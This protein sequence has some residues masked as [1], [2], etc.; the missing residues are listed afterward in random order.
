MVRDKMCVGIT[1]KGEFMVR[2]NPDEQESALKRKGARMMDF[3]HRP[4]KGFLFIS[5][6]GYTND[7]D[8]E[9]WLDMALR[10]NEIIPIKAKKTKSIR[11]KNE[12]ES[13]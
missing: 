7:S 3:T 5:E 8:L 2:I 12:R 9:A 1:N 4:M 6:V 11:P 13:G 10:Y